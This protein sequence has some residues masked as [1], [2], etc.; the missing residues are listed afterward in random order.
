MK[1]VLV[2]GSKGFVGKNLM[3]ALQRRSD[4]RVFG[5]D[6]DAT[7]AE[8]NRGLEEADCVFHLAGVNRPPR[9]EE[10][11]QINAGVTE[12]LLEALSQRHQRPLILLASSSQA[13]CDNPYG[14]SKRRAEELVAEFCERQGGGA[15]I[16]RLKNLFGKWCRPNYNSVVATF[17]HQTVNDIPLTV[18][19]PGKELELVY[20]DDVVSA[21]MRD[22]FERERPKGA[23]F[24]E[25]GPVS[26]ITVGQL[27]E[28]IRSFRDLRETLLIPDMSDAF[29][30]RLYATYLSYLRGE[31]VAYQPQIRTDARGALAEFFK[32]PAFGQV[33]I[34]RTYPGVVRGNHYHD[35]K[36]EK[37]CVLQGE[38][39]IRFRHVADNDAFEVRVRGEEFRIVDIPA[40]YTHSI[41]NVSE[42]EMVVLFWANEVFDPKATDT[43]YAEV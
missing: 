2:T 18:N 38:A 6:A 26:R 19:D 37:F 10:F 27:A 12:K 20:I 17:C 15:V 11:G 9:E 41:E 35:T 3:L 7:E 1:T 24:R 14:N 32:S 33:F 34:S 23:E 21:M 25:V 29:T 22:A 43:Y 39:I 13:A 30:R 40:G 31:Q 16:Y 5:V 28:R 8:W 4:L 36:V 42:G